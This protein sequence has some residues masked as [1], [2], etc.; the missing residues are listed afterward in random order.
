[1]VPGD[2]GEQPLSV[3][4]VEIVLRSESVARQRLVGKVRELFRIWRALGRVDAQ[5]VVAGCA[6]VDVGLVALATT[7]LRRRF[8]YSAASL[9]DFDFGRLGLKRRDLAL[10]RLGLRIAS[11][12]V[13]QTTEQAELCRRSLGRTP[14]VI[15]NIGEL[16][17]EA[18][19]MPSAFLW[20]GRVIPIKQ[21]L[22]YVELARLLPEAPFSMVTVPQ[23][24]QE[25][26]MEEL[27]RAA[28]SV[29][30]LELAGP[31]PRPEVMDLIERAVAVVSTS[32]YEGFP[33]VFLEAW[34]RGVPV[35]AL[36]HDPDQVIERHGLGECAH[37]SL[38]VLAGGARRLWLERAD[39]AELALRCR[40]YMETAHSKGV[41]AA[42]WAHVLGRSEAP[43]G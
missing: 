8:M 27:E 3:D 37:G 36:S 2:E 4:G 19:T 6:G 41:V 18:N 40:R 28:S 21:P 34:A 23:P 31:R 1:M 30:N 24:G 17:S 13:V 20:I 15:R 29:P 26:L 38:D 43:V 14:V 35:L 22:A 25:Q 39:R 9:A 10:Y 16:F 33:N 5:V 32:E 12:I 7:L 11:E 42:D